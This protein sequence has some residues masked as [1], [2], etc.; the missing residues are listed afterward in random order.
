MPLLKPS[1]VT[2]WFESHFAE[3]TPAQRVAWPLIEAGQSVLIVSLT[4]A[5]KTLAALLSVVSELASKHE[6][7]ELRSTRENVT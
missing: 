5:G 3:P 4:G 2:C 7:G 1:P 6:A